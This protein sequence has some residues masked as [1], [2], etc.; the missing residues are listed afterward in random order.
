MLQ[1]AGCLQP[2]V[3]FEYAD[4]TTK[5]ILCSVHPLTMHGMLPLKILVVPFFLALITLA[6]RHWG[7]GG[8][9]CWQAFQWLPARFFIF[10]LSNKAV[11]SQR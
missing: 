2:R 10:W 8:E 3:R 5:G 7:P 1:T 4:H 9:D 11:R 6:A